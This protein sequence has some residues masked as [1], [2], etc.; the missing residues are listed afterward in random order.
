MKQYPIIFLLLILSFG[1][2]QKKLSATLEKYQP[3]VHFSPGKVWNSDVMGLVS[4]DGRFHL[5]YQ[6]IPENSKSGK[7]EWKRA[8]SE[9]LIDWNRNESLNLPEGAEGI[10][11]SSVVVDAQNT[12]GLGKDGKAPWVALASEPAKDELQKNVVDF[13]SLALVYSIDGG[14]NWTKSPSLPNSNPSG[15]EKCRFPRISWNDEIKKWILVGSKGDHVAFYSS[16]DLLSWTF[17]SDFGTTRG[18]HGGVWESVDLFKLE[19][20]GSDETQWV[21]AVSID[22]GTLN[23]GSGTQYFVGNFDGHQFEYTGEKPKW[24][25][26]GKD[27]YAGIT[28]QDIKYGR[29]IFLGWMNNWQYANIVPTEKWRG[30]AT[31]ARELSLVKTGEKYF[32][33][34]LPVKELDV[35]NE[36]A[37]IFENLD[38]T[39][40]LLSEK[41]GKLNGAARLVLRSDSLKSFTLSF[42]NTEGEEIVIGY[43]AATRNYFIDRTRSGKVSF[44]KGFAKKQLAPRI[45]SGQAMDLTVILDQ[46]SIELFADG[47]LTTMTSLFFPNIPVTEMH[48]RSNE[49]FM[50][51]SVEYSRLKKIWN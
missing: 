4:E 49:G 10:L 20:K 11:F 5:F 50:L 39:D 36:E 29:R 25:D 23:G 6:V 28:C 27:N 19:V 44:E 48:I 12:S 18:A 14:Q 32:L 38:G 51:K 37:S 16:P 24:F 3:L 40:L 15:L 8:S 26:Y 46:A 47:G 34:S 2:S 43:D 41:T 7:L 35:L 9:N 45:S 17:E 1:C 31:I 13:G 30:A 21:L 22:N 33:R 42:S